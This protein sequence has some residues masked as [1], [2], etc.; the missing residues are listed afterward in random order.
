MECCS[1]LGAR[2]FAQVHPES[3][4]PRRHDFEEP[5]VVIFQGMSLCVKHFNLARGF[6]ADFPTDLPP[7]DILDKTIDDMEAMTVKH[8]R[9]TRRARRGGS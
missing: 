9:I 4:V 7:E 3:D 8:N 5:V 2:Q 6:P 1:C